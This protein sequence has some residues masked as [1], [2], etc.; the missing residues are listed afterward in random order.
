MP[1]L[2]DEVI[3]LNA[4]L[5]AL[6]GPAVR[7]RQQVFRATTVDEITWSDRVEPVARDFCSQRTIVQ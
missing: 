3:V 4:E 2:F 6:R 5:V 7:G 1:Q